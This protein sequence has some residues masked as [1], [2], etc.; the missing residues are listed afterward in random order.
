[1]PVLS[2]TP[3]LSSG[4]QPENQSIRL[5]NSAR[6]P[7]NQHNKLPAHFSLPLLQPF[8]LHESPFSTF[9]AAENKPDKTLV[10]L[11]G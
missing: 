2:H 6:D 5:N 3:A 8:P 9:N 11:T 1:V 4:Y 10:F 7:K